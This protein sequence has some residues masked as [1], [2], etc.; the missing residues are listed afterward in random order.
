MYIGSVDQFDTRLSGYDALICSEVIEHLY[1]P[2][3]D[4]FLDITLGQYSPPMMIVTTPN[5]EY[6]INFDELQYGTPNTMFRHDDHKFEWT[7]QE[8]EEWC[9]EGAREYNYD[10]EFKGIGLIVGKRDDLSVGHCTQACIFTRRQYSC[11][12]DHQENGKTLLSSQEDKQQQQS[13]QLV[14]HIEFPYY[15]EPPLT[16]DQAL[17]EIEKYIISLCQAEQQD[18]ADDNQYINRKVDSDKNSDNLKEQSSPILTSSSR[19]ESYQDVNWDADWSSITSVNSE[20][21]PTFA[22]TTEIPQSL[23]V[24][25]SWDDYEGDHCYNTCIKKEK[26]KRYTRVPQ[27]FPYSLLWGILR[28]RQVCKS[29]RRMVQILSDCPTS[30]EIDAEDLI[31]LK[32]FEVMND[33]DDDNIYDNHSNSD[34]SSETDEDFYS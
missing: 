22:L 32:A 23:T 3:L 2:T 8:F 25:S 13:H 20:N 17:V 9:H 6:N 16:D 34:Y 19:D 31:V 12:P 33:D 5:S 21:S 24:S 11:S 18:D 4:K 15:S 26:Q 29:E 30:Y 14:K 28:I 1:K 27:R 7:R 10:V